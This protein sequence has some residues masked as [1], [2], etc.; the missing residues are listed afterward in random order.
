[1]SS[2][3]SPA[4]ASQSTLKLETYPLNPDSFVLSTDQSLE[5]FPKHNGVAAISESFALN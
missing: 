5:M 2:I 1:M 3:S 4:I